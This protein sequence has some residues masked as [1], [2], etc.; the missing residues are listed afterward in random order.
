[1]LFSLFTQPYHDSSSG[2]IV[3]YRGRDVLIFHTAKL[4]IRDYPPKQIR[5][6]A[7]LPSIIAVILHNDLNFPAIFAVLVL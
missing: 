6:I 4:H 3:P 5:H 1:M 7:Q 2:R